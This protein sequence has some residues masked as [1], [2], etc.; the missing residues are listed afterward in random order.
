[1]SVDPSVPP[2]LVR[3][4]A[5]EHHD[6][7]PRY[8]SVLT[9]HDV[10]TVARAFGTSVDTVLQGFGFGYRLTEFAPESHRFSRFFHDRIEHGRVVAGKETITERI[11]NRDSDPTADPNRF[12]V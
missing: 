4:C 10:A 5:C 2:C 6:T 12:T 3:D 9:E 8:D 1:M 7:K 11:F